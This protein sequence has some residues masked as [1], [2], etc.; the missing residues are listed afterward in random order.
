VTGRHQ[1]DRE[2][3]G[4][5]HGEGLGQRERLEQ[6]P[7]LGFEREHR[8]EGNGDDRETEEQRE[9]KDGGPIIWQSYPEDEKL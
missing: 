2:Q 5:A 8:Q 1:R 7:F 9:G 6:T 4:P 3:R